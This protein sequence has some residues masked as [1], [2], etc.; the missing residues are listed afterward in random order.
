MQGNAGRRI[1][2]IFPGDFRFHGRPFSSP[3]RLVSHSGKHEFHDPDDFEAGGPDVFMSET[4][5]RVDFGHYS[6]LPM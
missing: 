6:S 1:A 3:S 4:L 2:R 5:S